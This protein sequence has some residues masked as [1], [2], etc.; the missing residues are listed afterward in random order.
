MVTPVSSPTTTMPYCMV[1]RVESGSTQGLGNW[2]P[3]IVA[4]GFL[5]VNISSLS[6]DVRVLSS[7]AFYYIVCA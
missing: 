6:N 1:D 7:P 5:P 4:D 3:E 2:Y